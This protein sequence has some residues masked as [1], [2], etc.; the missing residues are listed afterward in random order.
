MIS[1]L[2]SSLAKQ[3]EVGDTISLVSFPSGGAHLILNRPA[4]LNALTI[5]Q[6]NYI[7]AHIEEIS[8]YKYLLV[9]GS[10]ER[11]F[12]AGGDV[13]SMAEWAKRKSGNTEWF[14]IEYSLNLRLSKL[15]KPMIS[16]WKGVVM[17]GGVGLSIYGSH[18]IATTSTVFA[19]PET[20][21][22]F[23]PDVGSSYFLPRIAGSPL[24]GSEKFPCS[25]RF[26]GLGLYLA[27][28]G[29]RVFGSD[30]QKFGLATHFVNNIDQFQQAITNFNGD[31]IYGFINKHTDSII[32]APNHDVIRN[33]SAID[34]SQ[35]KS[36]SHLNAKSY[37]AY[38]LESIKEFFGSYEIKNDF[39]EFWL[40]LTESSSAFAKETV[41]TLRSKCPLTIKIAYELFHR[42][43]NPSESLASCLDREFKVAVLLTNDDPHN[44]LQGVRAQLIDKG[45]GRPPNYIPSSIEEVTD[46][47]VQKIVNAEHVLELG[48]NELS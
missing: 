2:F 3:L 24:P 48:L 30:V 42:G 6:T 34:H 12:C 32:D 41:R 46:D 9:S 19:M 39:N 37:D 16:L 38:K 7:H 1:R 31:D 43:C 18:R 17:G 44:F 8:K 13:L 14:G 45:R 4:S 21:I 36:R 33:E 26:S 23:I 47:M 10:G 11:A 5:A 20:G 27:L 35:R 15:K 40:N 28:T 22:G 25:S 29:D